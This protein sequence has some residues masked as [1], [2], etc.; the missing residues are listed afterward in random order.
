MSVYYGDRAAFTSR[1]LTSSRFT[2]IGVYVHHKLHRQTPLTHS[3]AVDSTRHHGQPDAFRQVSYLHIG[4]WTGHVSLK[5]VG[6]FDEQI[7][8]LQLT[9]PLDENSGR[10]TALA[11]HKVNLGLSRYGSGGRKVREWR[12]ESCS[13]HNHSVPA[14]LHR[15][16]Q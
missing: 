3:F 12:K 8:V 2:A 14:C 5:V 11:F 1:A 6:P 16:V 7:E 15:L 4:V 13:I 9:H 10:T